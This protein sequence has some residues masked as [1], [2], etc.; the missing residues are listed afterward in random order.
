M[1]DKYKEFYE[2]KHKRK[3]DEETLKNEIYYS[4]NSK[5]DTVHDTL[6]YMRDLGKFNEGDILIKKEGY[7][8]WKTDENIWSTESF[9]RS[10]EAPRKYMVVHVDEVN[11]PYVMKIGMKGDLCGNMTCIAGHDINTVR[12]EYDPDF[13][14]HQILADEEDA[15]DPQEIYREKRDEYFKTRRRKSS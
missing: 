8:D 12:Y 14:D 13:I 6:I 11:L 4:R 3:L 2:K 5:A 15:F 9:S 1:I 10:N 7:Y